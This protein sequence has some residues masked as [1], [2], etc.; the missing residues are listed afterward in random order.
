MSDIQHYENLLRELIIDILYNEFGIGYE[1]NFG[2]TPER[3][4][5]WEERRTEEYKKHNKLINES[6]LLYYSDFYDLKKVISTNWRLFKDIF[7]EKKRFEVLFDEIEIYRNTTAHGRELLQFQEDMI[8]GILGDLK[9]Q[10]IMHRNK[11]ESPEDY[12]LRILKVS[13]NL[14]NVYDFANS[15]SYTYNNRILRP[16]DNLEFHIDAFDPKG[17]LIKYFVRIDG[18]PASER[19]E[20]NIITLTIK[21][22]HVGKYLDIRLVAVT[23]EK[24]DNSDGISFLYTVIPNK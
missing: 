7:R 6:R 17:R 23:E 10:I 16:G 13:D 4:N 20:S 3:F 8:A 21:D 1:N 15:D 18:I 9:T 19:I 14:G 24:Y 12:F 5:K 11:N 22:E 2:I